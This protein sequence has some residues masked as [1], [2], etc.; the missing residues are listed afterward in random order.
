MFSC[1]TVM[2][3]FF[4]MN[5][6][7]GQ[8]LSIMPAPNQS[9]FALGPANAQPQM[10]F[11]QQLQPTQQQQQLRT[12]KVEE[13]KQSQ[14][15]K[16][17]PPRH[18]A[19]LRSKFYPSKNTLARMQQE[20]EERKKADEE[21][22]AI[23]E[24]TVVNHD[25]SL[26]VIPEQF[27][28]Q[29]ELQKSV[30]R[31]SE[32]T[33]N[34]DL[35]TLFSKADQENQDVELNPSPNKLP[36]MSEKVMEDIE[37]EASAKPI[38]VDLF[39]VD[40]EPIES[41]RST[42]ASMPADNESAAQPS[43]LSIEELHSEDATT[44]KKQKTSISRKI[45]SEKSSR[46]KKEKSGTDDT[47][48]MTTRVDMRSVTPTVLKEIEAKANLVLTSE[49]ERL[50]IPKLRI[51]MSLIRPNIVTLKTEETS[52]PIRKS[53]KSAPSKINVSKVKKVK[54]TK[55][56]EESN[57]E[58]PSIPK[59]RLSTASKSAS[60][61]PVAKADKPV[62]KSRSKRKSSTSVAKPDRILEKMRVK[63]MKMYK[64]TNQS[65]FNAFPQLD[66]DTTMMI[67]DF[68]ASQN[69]TMDEVIAS[70]DALWNSIENIEKLLTSEELQYC[71]SEMADD[72][73]SDLLNLL[74]VVAFLNRSRNDNDIDRFSR[75]YNKMEAKQD[76]MF[77]KTE[78]SSEEA[79][80]ELLRFPDF[81]P[82]AFSCS[83]DRTQHYL[84]IDS[85]VIPVKGGL[86]EAI[87]SVVAATSLCNLQFHPVVGDVV[88]FFYLAA[89]LKI[90]HAEKVPKSIEKA[91]KVVQ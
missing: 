61:S 56:V 27:A 39:V 49:E 32:E 43:N 42:D 73:D 23:Q 16:L 34:M 90:V 55:A 91:L 85:R 51:P 68:A 40:G 84:F 6:H 53:R 21:T 60:S 58:L 4:Y 1:N 36:R 22:A 65:V 19:L 78:S 50:P 26:S 45:R 83:S 76:K 54:T 30:K 66:I 9:V 12:V 8:Q 77:N 74:Y 79:Q 2:N 46:S 86:K 24:R 17:Q 10:Q 82:L 67:A 14:R 88:R 41:T 38:P 87:L 89:G 20:E 62:E 48:A 15:P 13:Q 80:S 81:Y 64:K 59:L 7:N 71:K 75:I 5:H 52:T 25:S 31:K 72:D 69:K 29:Q 44:P 3:D 63:R 11:L 57:V 28:F 47:K 37:E 33:I 35:M 70:N 18:P